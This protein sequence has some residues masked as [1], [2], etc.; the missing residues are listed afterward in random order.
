MKETFFWNKFFSDSADFYLSYVD[1]GFLELKIRLLLKEYNLNDFFYLITL[2][3]KT[4]FII[5]DVSVSSLDQSRRYSSSSGV[6]NG[7]A[8]LWSN[9]KK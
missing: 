7:V 8:I 6:A 4:C 5:F 9:S 2:L 1:N 3:P